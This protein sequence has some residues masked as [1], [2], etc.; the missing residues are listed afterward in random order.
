MRFIFRY[1]ALLI[2][3]I[4][5]SSLESAMNK[6]FV[7]RPHTTK[8]FGNDLSLFDAEYDVLYACSKNPY[9]EYSFGSLYR[10]DKNFKKYWNTKLTV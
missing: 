4:M 9:G 2:L 10:G 7:R 5:I 8:D 1:S 3:V 6:V